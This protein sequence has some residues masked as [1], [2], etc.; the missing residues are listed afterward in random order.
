[1]LSLDHISFPSVLQV[2]FVV[3]VDY[4]SIN[5]GALLREIRTRGVDFGVKCWAVKIRCSIWRTAYEN[6]RRMCQKIMAGELNG[7]SWRNVGPVKLRATW[8]AARGR[9]HC[10]FQI[11]SKGIPEIVKTI[12]IVEEE[13]YCQ[14]KK[15]LPTT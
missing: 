3:K 4:S 13:I 12:N 10:K 15:V 8:K 2:K 11:A 7:S 5:K 1:M 6:G 9:Q 14:F